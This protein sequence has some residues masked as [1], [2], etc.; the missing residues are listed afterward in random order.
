MQLSILSAT[1]YPL[2]SAGIGSWLLVRRS[3]EMKK[4][5]VFT[6][7]EVWFA[8]TRHSH[9]PEA[10]LN[11]GSSYTCW[12]PPLVGFHTG[13]NLFPFNSYQRIYLC[14]SFIICLSNNRIPHKQQQDPL[15]RWLSLWKDRLP[16]PDAA[17]K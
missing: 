16:W 2:R 6:V 7:T 11:T 10:S 14:F 4:G 13:I 1:I 17:L 3:L 15:S 12:L 8:T 9:L 5:S